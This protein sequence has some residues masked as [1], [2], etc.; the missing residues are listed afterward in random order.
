MTTEIPTQPI[1]ALVQQFE[2]IDLAKLTERGYDQIMQTTLYYDESKKRPMTVREYKKERKALREGKRAPFKL[3]GEPHPDYANPPQ[4]AFRKQDVVH[5]V[6]RLAIPFVIDPLCFPRPMTKD[7]MATAYHYPDAETWLVSDEDCV[8]PHKIPDPED[9]NPGVVP[10]FTPDY[11]FVKAETAILSK[12]D[13]LKSQVQWD[14]AAAGGLVAEETKLDFQEEYDALLEAF[15]GK[16]FGNGCVEGQLSRLAACWNLRDR[17]TPAN[18]TPFMAKGAEIEAL[19][20]WPAKDIPFD[21][22]GAPSRILELCDQATPKI[23]LYNANAS[24]DSESG[25]YLQPHGTPPKRG[26]SIDIEINWADRI[27][28]DIQKLG[29][30]WVL[31]HRNWLTVSKLKPKAEIYEKDQFRD[32][33][34]NIVVMNGCTQMINGIAIKGPFRNF[35]APSVI[36]PSLLGFSVWHGGIGR[37]LKMSMKGPCQWVYADNLYVVYEY[38]GGLYGVFLDMEKAESCHRLADLRMLT[39]RITKWWGD[40]DETWAAILKNFVPWTSINNV[41]VLGNQTVKIPG[42][43]TGAACTAVL[44]HQKTINFLIHW[45][46]SKVP[47]AFKFDENKKV[48]VD[49][50]GFEQLQK[51]CGLHFKMEGEPQYLGQVGAEPT[52]MPPYLQL[53]LLGYDAVKMETAEGERY[54]AVLKKERL[55]GSLCFPKRELEKQ[56]GASKG[57]KMMLHYARLRALYIVGAWHYDFISRAVAAVCGD[58]RSQAR[59]NAIPDEM[60]GAMRQI[61]DVTDLEWDIIGPLFMSLSIPS[62]YDVFALNGERPQ[63]DLPKME[64]EHSQKPV[65]TEEEFFKELETAYEVGTNWAEE[66]TKHMA[67]AEHPALEEVETPEQTELAKLNV[68]PPK[69]V[70]RLPKAIDKGKIDSLWKLLRDVVK[71]IRKKIPRNIEISTMSNIKPSDMSVPPTRFFLADIASGMQL[72]VDELRYVYNLKKVNLI[73]ACEWKMSDGPTEDDK[74]IQKIAHEVHKTYT[75]KGKF[76]P[77]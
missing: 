66:A 5:F 33:T 15:Q 63:S 22:K 67:I 58:L 24:K 9:A 73:P 26:E 2:K 21:L 27:Y 30:N 72:Q 47:I 37:L 36:H 35:P 62:V 3:V 44:N 77:V 74:L 41:A 38:K 53:D 16:F 71:V 45:R 40:V 54:F 17:V 10:F 57:Y 11:G 43:A 4:V 60:E 14:L 51:D 69:S 1:H 68:K 31:E 13:L 8:A 76:M 50:P 46:Q 19:W 64:L 23:N 34:R 39:E 28:K 59:K 52:D 75:S 32:K 6:N 61:L 25:L 7:Q 42:L 18:F 49:M 56:R 70:A 20:P 65:P 12:L 48:W 55:M 29:F